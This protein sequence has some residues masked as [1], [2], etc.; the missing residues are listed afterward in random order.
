MPFMRLARESA[1]GL[2][3]DEISVRKDSILLSCTIGLMLRRVAKRA[4]ILVDEQNSLLAL[5]PV[6]HGRFAITD[7]FR[8]HCPASKINVVCNRYKAEWSAKKKLL[9]A[10][11]VFNEPDR[12]DS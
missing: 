10:K 7:V 3:H 6:S 4:N 5:E 2:K 12:S 1:T 8:V 11:V 9:I